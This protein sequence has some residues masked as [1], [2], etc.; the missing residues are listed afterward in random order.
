MSGE[1]LRNLVFN[2]SLL[3]T[4]SIIANVFFV[5]YHEKK[6]FHSVLIG[7]ITGAIGILLIMTTAKLTS[8]II[9]DTRS[10]LISAVGMFFGFIPTIIA[11]VIIS[12]YRM[13]LGGDGALTGVLVTFFTAGVGLLW[14][15]FRLPRILSKKKNVWIEFY[16]FGVAAHIVMLACMFAMPRDMIFIVLKGITLPVLLLYP[17]GSLL[18]CLLLY[19]ALKNVQMQ[20][21]LESSELRFRTM[22]EQAPVGI[23]ITGE[24][25]VSY[26][27]LLFEKIVG[28]P[29]EEILSQAWRD[30]TH[31]DDVQRDLEQY[32]AL[33]SGRIKSYAM[34]KRYIRPNGEIIWVHMILAS[35]R[36]NNSSV[37]SHLCMIQDITE[38]K[39]REEEV[40][41]LN[42]H[43]ILTGLYNRAFFDREQ[44]R[45]DSKEFLPLSVITGDI[46]GLKLINDAFGH[47]EGDKLLISTARTLKACCR[48]T[49]VV[50][51]TGGDEFS[52]LLPNTDESTVKLIYERIRQLCEDTTMNTQSEI[53]YSSISLGFATKTTSDQSFIK[54]MKDAEEHMYRR[55]LLAHK[56]LHSAIISSIK[57]TMFE[58]SNET[59]EHAER[60]SA[61]SKK[62]GQALSLDDEDLIALELVSTLHD[63]GKISIDQNILTKPGPLSEEEWVEM[64][65]HPEVGYRIAQTVPE[66][67]QISEYILCHHERWDGHGYPQSISGEEIPLLSRILSLVDSYDAMTQDRAYRKAL[68]KAAAIA[69]IA[70]NAGTQFDP[71]IAKVFIEIVSKDDFL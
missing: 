34:D 36:I 11:A 59:E 35:L 28:R 2:A 61:L 46:D 21:G 8:G 71:E 4:I 45:L 64:K 14:H 60:L 53:Y 44:V 22:F 23:L 1:F 9:F 30:Y 12:I 50:A 7:I 6:K 70:K 3:L 69:E 15:Y 32:D 67:R 19:S 27:N 41:Y 58:K 10:I 57:T 48:K 52:I 20:Q 55:K 47:A 37:D 49:D 16:L 17:L 24:N 65:K 54:V 18:L 5:E 42:Y 13:I 38:Q 33:M 56:S 26:A 43:D 51:R 29:R 39:H 25:N 40:L 62:L 66:L 68:P 63:I 31:P